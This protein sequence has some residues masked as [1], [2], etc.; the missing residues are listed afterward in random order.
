MKGARLLVCNDSG[1]S[2]LAAGVGLPSVV[3]FRRD[4]RE[5][6][7]PPDRRLH[8]SVLDADGDRSDR[9]IA[10]ARDLMHLPSAMGSGVDR[11]TS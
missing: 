1:V 9:V 4:A 5:R 11:Y 10:A 2:H 3:V 8:R 6:W 7:A